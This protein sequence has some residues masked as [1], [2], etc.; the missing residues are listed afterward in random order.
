MESSEMRY[1][2]AMLARLAHSFAAYGLS[3]RPVSEASTHGD[4]YGHT[5]LSAEAATTIVS[6]A[7][8]MLEAAVVADRLRGASWHAIA[9]ALEGSAECAAAITRTWIAKRISQVLKLSN[10]HARLD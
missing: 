2:P 9:D 7:M 4:E 6:E 1:T 3:E 10:F 5:A 8:A